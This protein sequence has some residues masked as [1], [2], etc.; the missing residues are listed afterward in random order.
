MAAQA[1]PTHHGP[2]QSEPAIEAGQAEPPQE[3]DRKT[4]HGMSNRTDDTGRGQ[5]GDRRVADDEAG[6]AERQG[7]K[8]RRRQA[9]S[10]TRAEQEPCQQE[11]RTDS[12]RPNCGVK[13]A[14]VHAVTIQKGAAPSDLGHLAD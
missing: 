14:N 11:D 13:L 8:Q 5:G 6:E 9:N 12:T 3:D 4:T 7:S 2:F 1:K 10:P